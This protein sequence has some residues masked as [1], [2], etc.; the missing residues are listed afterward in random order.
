MAEEAPEAVPAADAPAEAPAPASEASSGPA[1]DPRVERFTAIIRNGLS[2]SPISRDP[3]SW[4]ALE[5]LL[6]GVVQELLG[7]P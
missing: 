2:N 7:E 3:Q 4:S 6:P 1:V 5:T